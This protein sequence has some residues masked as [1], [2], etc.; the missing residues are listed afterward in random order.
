MKFLRLYKIYNLKVFLLLIYIFPVEGA[1]LLKGFPFNEHINILFLIIFLLILKKINNKNTL[2]FLVIFL[3][4]KLFITFN[5]NNMWSICVNDE[6]T[7]V[8]NSFEYEYFENKCVKSFDSA[9]SKNKYTVKEW[10]LNYQNLNNNYQ[11][12]GSNA[13]NFPLGYLNHSKFNIYDLRRDWLPFR[14]YAIKQLDEA[15]LLNVEYVGEVTIEFL[16]SQKKVELPKRYL[17]PL[18]KEIEVPKGSS[19]VIIYYKFT[20]WKFEPIPEIKSGYPYEFYGRLII[21]DSTNSRNLEVVSYLLVLSFITINFKSISLDLKKIIVLMLLAVFIGM[22]YGGFLFPINIYS[23][24]GYLIILYCFMNKS[25]LNLFIIFLSVS[26]LIIDP[27]WNQL[28]FLVKPSGSDILTYENQA[29]LIFEGDGLR[30]GESIFWYS[31]GYRYILFVI[32]VIF[33]DGWMVSWQLILSLCVYLLST[34]NERVNLATFVFAIFLLLDNVR[35]LFLFGMSETVSL[36]LVIYSIYLVKSDKNSRIATLSLSIAVLI[37]PELII[38]SLLFLFLK[39]K[40]VKNLTLF[41]VLQTLPLLHNIYFGN[42]FVFYSTAGTYQRNINFDIF[43]N[44]NYLFFNPFSESLLIRLGN[45]HVYIGFFIVA[46]SITNYFLDLTK[47]QLKFSLNNY[48]TFGLLCLAPY[49][50]YDPKLFYPR[51]VIIGICLFSL[52]ENYLLNSK[53][54]DLKKLILK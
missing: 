2:I 21:D 46:I 34:A 44:L 37:R 53:L 38:F 42:K 7:P 33:G 1:Y 30:G 10:S 23:L 50:I 49:L 3:I 24:F 6:L 14:L 17:N 40:N 20:N 48:F 11:W 26:F 39:L 41:F 45:F 51:H 13:A 25:D 28:N 52:N 47:L 9:F 22:K 32:H 31:P 43:E 16:P 54:N 36:L 29:R 35:S 15:K 19:S 5:N 18:N 4:F 12:M 8:Q 27:P